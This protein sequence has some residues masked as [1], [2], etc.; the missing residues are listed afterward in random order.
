LGRRGDFEK[1]NSYTLELDAACWALT[2]L[3]LGVQIPTDLSLEALA[4]LRMRP[5]QERTAHIP[6]G[7]R[8]QGAFDP[9]RAMDDEV[10][11]QVRSR[12]SVADPYDDDY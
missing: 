11:E 7:R 9:A 5:M 3:L 1:G 12:W 2:D 8:S 10:R 6:G 4:D